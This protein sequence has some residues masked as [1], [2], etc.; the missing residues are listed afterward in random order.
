MQ[1]HRRRG[2][3][4]AGRISAETLPWM[5]EA[6]GASSNEGEGSNSR[7][8]FDQATNARE[9]AIRIISDAADSQLIQTSSPPPIYNEL[10]DSPTGGSPNSHSSSLPDYTSDERPPYLH[11]IQA[12]N[13][14]AIMTRWF[15][16]PLRRNMIERR[17]HNSVSQ[18]NFEDRRRATEVAVDNWYENGL[19]RLRYQEQVLY[20]AYCNWPEWLASVR[21]HNNFRRNLREYDEPLEAT[22]RRTDEPFTFAFGPRPADTPP[23]APPLQI[24][25]DEWDRWIE[26][27]DRWGSIWMQV[28]DGNTPQQAQDTVDEDMEDLI[29]RRPYYFSMP[30]LQVRAPVP[31]PEPGSEDHIRHQSYRD[32]FATAGFSAHNIEAIFR[33]FYMR[34]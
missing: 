18:T 22:H 10:P 5:L 8:N 9:S 16:G 3:F 17:M 21:R 4:I 14:R 11:D 13:D 1:P 2:R 26:S 29:G 23:A 31:R 19:I 25:V 27:E 28:L 15:T 20:S 24:S 30:Q 7:N 12:N 34:D 6:N 32:A 33:L